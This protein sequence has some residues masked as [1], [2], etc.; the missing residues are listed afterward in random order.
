[1]LLIKI[2]IISNNN[3]NNFI[4]KFNTVIS[5]ISKLKISI[6]RC[7]V[8]KRLKLK[9]LSSLTFHKIIIYIYIKI[10]NSTIEIASY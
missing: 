1:M 6:C 10:Y 3:C 8:L 4:I 5:Y 9:V 7:L 2:I